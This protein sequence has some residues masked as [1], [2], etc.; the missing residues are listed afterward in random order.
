MMLPTHFRVAMASLRS[1]PIR[2]SLTTLGIVIGVTS[3]TL[4]MA[5]GEGARQTVAGQLAGL[6]DNFI[7][8][9]PG[10]SDQRSTFSNYNP[11]AI[12]PASTL[13]ERDITTI[14]NIEGVEGVAPIMFVSGTI[15]KQDQIYKNAAII[16]T[17]SD[18]PKLLKL[19]M[20]SGEFV[21]G[22][23][24]RDTVVLGNRLALEMLGTDQARGQEILLKGRV[25]TVIGVLKPTNSAINAV[26]V[27]LDRGA[28]VSLEDGKS[29]NQGIAQVQQVVLKSKP[30]ASVATVAA[31]VDAALLKNHDSERDFSVY[32][33]SDA[34]NSSNAFYSIL[35]VLT[36]A[37]AAVALVVGGIGIMN[38]ML[39]SVTERTREIGIR[40]A[41]GATD[42]QIFAQFII[43]SLAITF[44]GGVIGLIFA[45]GVAFLIGIFLTFHPAL[46][47]SIVG[48]AMGLSMLVGVIFGLFPALKASRKDPIAALRQYE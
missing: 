26:G 25:H 7:L 37:I 24:V 3:I 23:T 17:N 18:F 43:E 16:A 34:A 31:Q 2:T 21:D 22:T 20:Q 19:T 8:V 39:V 29:F 28:Y 40:K 9:K 6:G 33:G 13:T 35:V 10:T 4:V 36:S 41:L 5:L 42:G 11:F 45:Y 15:K 12:A 46:S 48:I 32:E 14:K 44:V 47:W 27:D 1:T 30:N 38:I